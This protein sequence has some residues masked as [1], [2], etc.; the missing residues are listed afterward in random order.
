[1]KISAET[2]RE[3]GDTDHQCI[4]DLKS[5]IIR[6]IV[7]IGILLL[8]HGR[9]VWLALHSVYTVRTVYVEG[10]VHYTEDEIMEI[11]RSAPLCRLITLYPVPKRECPILGLPGTADTWELSPRQGPPDIT[12]SMISSSV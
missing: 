5:K 9:G 6:R 11:V 2:W 7:I 4:R 1:M 3:L 12:I 10:N 8:G